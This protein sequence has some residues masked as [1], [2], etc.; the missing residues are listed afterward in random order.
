MNE[1]KRPLI[2]RILTSFLAIWI[3]VN[4]TQCIL[5]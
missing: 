3:A 5:G 1:S 4:C 2:V